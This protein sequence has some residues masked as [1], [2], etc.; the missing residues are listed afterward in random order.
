MI[1]A[2][3]TPAAR[4]HIG[5]LKRAIGPAADRLERK[6]RTLLR[7]RGY[8][9]VQTKALTAI[10]PA[11]AA[12]LRSLPQ[13]QEQVEY[14][15][16]RLAKLNVPPEAVKAAL[17]DFARL[18]D[19]VCGGRF[20]P[21]REQLQLAT[22]LTLN[23]AY[24][25][26]REA[27]AQALFGLARAEVE[28]GGLDDL[29][30]RFIRVLIRA[31]GARSG[32]AILAEGAARPGFELDFKTPRPWLPREQTLLEVA[33][34]RCAAAMDRVRLEEENRRLQAE[35]RR[36]EEEERRRIGRE[37]HDEAG[38]S[39]LLLRLQLEMIERRAPEAL[40]GALSEA[41]GTAGRTVEEL[42]RIVAALSPAVLERLGLESALRRLAARFASMHPASLRLRIA[43]VDGIPLETQQVIYR[44]AQESLQN[45]AKHS[46]ATHVNLS[47][48][49]ADKSIR[50]RVTDN[51]A[52]FCAEAANRKPM[53]FGLAG[54]RERAALLG[55]TLA[56]RST[57]GR[58][59]TVLLQLPR[60]ARVG[61]HGQNSN[62]LN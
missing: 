42:R 49:G 45:I 35:A 37:L 6:F 24:Y 53:A 9:A 33:A 18:L 55:G 15:G 5:R 48:S 22:I 56:V 44:V 40:K 38:Q 8:D 20:G 14:H 29:L 62:S 21:A 2:V 28:A 12:R 58:G 30:R 26:V 50:L 7:R 4:R 25:Q 46:H 47:L 32:R 3:L 39:L 61:G 51:G 16:R 17:G 23:G 41:R 34:E 43:P 60:R 59:A 57:P 10:T 1:G 19:P 27:E 11:A 52:G 13:F 36:A 31:L 54:M